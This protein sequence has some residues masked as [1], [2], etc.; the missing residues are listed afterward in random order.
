MYEII[1]E[2]DTKIKI[3]QAYGWF[4]LKLHELFGNEYSVIALLSLFEMFVFS[5]SNIFVIIGLAVI[6][7]LQIIR[8]KT[9]VEHITYS[10]VIQLKREY[11]LTTYVFGITYLRDTMD[12]MLTACVQFCLKIGLFICIKVYS[13][14]VMYA[15]T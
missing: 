8:F 3:I 1:S 14:F 13:R 6:S 12:K 9:L 2:L 5:F 10:S 4:L 15:R 11:T 7:D